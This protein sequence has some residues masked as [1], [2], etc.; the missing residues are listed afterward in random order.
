MAWE[1]TPITSL[2]Q[3]RMASRLDAKASSFG[4]TK[5]G[6]NQGY[7]PTRFRGVLIQ[8]ATSRIGT[9]S[10]WAAQ[11]AVITIPEGSTC[12]RCSTPSLGSWEGKRKAGAVERV[13]S[14]RNGDFE[15]SGSVR[16]EAQG[17]R[18]EPGAQVGGSL[19]EAG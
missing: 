18:L 5:G 11:G 9:M 8:N 7:V 6:V 16:V 13:K 2:A 4:R 3:A 10:R 1:V 17:G 12:N 19:D 14:G 15:V